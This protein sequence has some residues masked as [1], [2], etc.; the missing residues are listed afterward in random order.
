MGTYLWTFVGTMWAH[1]PRHAHHKAQ[2]SPDQRT[3]TRNLHDG[4]RSRGSGEVGNGDAV[5]A[6]F[7]RPASSLYRPFG[8]VTVWSSASRRRAELL[9]ISRA[10]AY[11]LVARGELPV[12]R[13]GSTDCRPQGA[14]L[15]SG[16]DAAGLHLNRARSGSGPIVL[17]IG[18]MVAGAEEYYL[19]MVAEGQRG[20]L[21][22]GRRVAGHLARQRDRRP[23]VSAGAGATPRTCG[24]SLA[25]ISPRTAPSSACSGTLGHPGGWLR[26]DLLGP[27]VRLPPLRPRLPRAPPPPSGP[28]HDHAVAEALGVPGAPRHSSPAG[29]HDGLRRI[30][31]AGLVAA[32]FVHRTSRTGD[33]QL[34]THVLAANAVRGEPT[35]AGPPPTPGCCTSMPAP[36]ASSTRP[37][38]G[39][40]LVE[41]LGVS[42]RSCAPRQRP[43]SSGF[44]ASC[45]RRFSTRRA[46]IEEYLPRGGSVT[47][48][49]RVGRAGH[50]GPQGERTRTSDR[51][52]PTCGRGGG[53]GPLEL[54]VDPDARL[55]R[56]RAAS[57]RDPRAPPD[58]ELA[59]GA[60]RARRPHGPRLD[61]R[62]TRPRARH[63]GTA[64]RRG[65]ARRHRA[66]RRPVL[67]RCRR[68]GRSGPGPRRRAS[69]HDHRAARPRGRAPRAGRDPRWASS[70]AVDVDRVERRAVAPPQP[71]PTSSGAMVSRFVTS[72][73][74]RRGGRRQSGRRQDHRALAG[75]AGLRGGGLRGHRAR[76]LSARA[77]EELEASAG[78]S[79]SRWPASSVRSRPGP[80]IFGAEMSLVV[81]EAGMVGT[82]DPGQAGGAGRTAGRQVGPRGRSPPAPRDRGRRGLRP[83]GDSPRGHRAHRE[84]APARRVGAHRPRRAAVGRRRRGPRPPTSARADPPR[85]GTSAQAR[86]AG[87]RAMA[88]GPGIGADA[89]MLAASRRDVDALNFLARS[90]QAAVPRLGP[91]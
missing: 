4:A 86:S 15:C 14:A 27:E 69:A 33:P 36:P 58:R 26:P 67:R 12:I 43:K 32:A 18:K 31:T 24:A 17:S 70:A 65:S 75:P 40:A 84:P 63:R 51:C 78:M 44:D 87:D 34:H 52:A 62:A 39:P 50:Q 54:G 85:S 77:A 16:R 3:T 68:R 57:T 82:R 29:A 6:T 42:L 79:R 9:G 76:A 90:R 20:V 91:T 89:V 7:L 83:P 48:H 73:E 74:R 55:S 71:F 10:F 64:G 81:D 66:A 22:R 61:L 46:E 23:R 35:A 45:S 21:H 59:A 60:A 5:G 88:H 30:G 1:H 8:A 49:G 53:P 37:S 11:E 13:L 56:P 19:S 38:F 72:G 25:G 2:R 28:S 47:A 41:S 80:R